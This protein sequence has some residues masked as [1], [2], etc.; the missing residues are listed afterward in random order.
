MWGTKGEI[1][2]AGKRFSAEK[3]ENKKTSYLASLVNCQRFCCACEHLCSPQNAEKKVVV[4]IAI[5]RP[6]CHGFSTNG[7]SALPGVPNTVRSRVGGPLHATNGGPF[8]AR[9]VLLCDVHSFQW[10]WTFVISG[11]PAAPAGPNLLDY[12][13]FKLPA[14]CLPRSEIISYSIC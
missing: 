11:P 4:A 14:D 5:M 2:R 12:L 8:S 7:L 9:D 1:N 6:S 10:E 3:R 13:T